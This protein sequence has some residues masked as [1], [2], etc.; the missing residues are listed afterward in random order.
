V[1]TVG[2]AV[3]RNSCLTVIPRWV[4]SRRSWRMATVRLT[5][6]STSAITSTMTPAQ[7]ASS[8]G[9]LI[10]ARTPSQMTARRR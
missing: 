1:T 8:S 4:A 6:S 3:S 2:S 7:N 10:S 9:G 5:E